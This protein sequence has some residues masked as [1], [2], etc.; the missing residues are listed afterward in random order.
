MK[1][2]A[3]RLR[4]IRPYYRDI[5]SIAEVI[6]LTAIFYYF[7]RI[8]YTHGIPGYPEYYGRGR[9]VLVLVY[10]GMLWLL[11]KY[12][13]GF[14]FGRIRL[15]FLI[16]L[17]AAVL[18]VVNI[19]T[20]LELSLTATSMVAKRPVF[21]ATLWQFVCILIFNFVVFTAVKRYCR[22]NHRMLALGG[23]VKKE[24]IFDG[25]KVVC[26]IEGDYGSGEPGVDYDT[27]L[28]KIEGYDAV[29]LSEERKD[30]GE[31]IDHCLGKHI[32]VYFTYKGSL[33]YGENRARKG[34]QGLLLVE[35]YGEKGEGFYRK[36][37]AFVGSS[38]D[39]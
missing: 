4:R 14:R 29:L 28:K 6:L 19:I 38:L 23:N 20:Y 15:S 11:M 22:D 2:F 26:V 30:K 33:L 7:W 9:F 17:Q 24:D 18:L 8:G 32:P 39:S 36:L 35:G 10:G 13:G 1:E 31:I 3:V 21:D 12:T 16:P 27:F 34:E 37:K 5:L 25:Y